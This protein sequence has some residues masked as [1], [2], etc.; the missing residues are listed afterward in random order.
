MTL[1]LFVWIAACGDDTLPAGRDAGRTDPARDSG[2][3]HGEDAGE[4]PGSDSGVVRF[5]AG[6]PS[7][8]LL[9]FDDYEYV[10]DR[11]D[12]AGRELFAA[13]GYP[14]SKSETWDE[15]ASGYIYTTTT[16][17]G[18]SEPFPG[19][20]SSRVLALEARNGTFGGQ[21][22]FYLEIG[23]A[24][25]STEQIP[26]NVWLQFWVLL[27]HAGE[28]QSLIYSNE[29]FLYPCRA[30]YPCHDLR[31]LVTFGVNSYQPF[32]ESLGMSSG[33]GA[34]IA[35]IADTTN[36]EIINPPAPEWDRWKLGHTD[37]S[38]RIVSNRWTLVRIHFDT[39]TTSG[40][41]EAWM[42]GYGGAWVQIARWIDGEGG[43]EWNIAP[44]AVGGHRTLRMPTT[45]GNFVEGRPNHDLWM[46]LDDF[47]MAGTMDALPV[48]PDEP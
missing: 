48:Y 34:F 10:V 12:A 25:G 5:D 30:E 39:S 6:A 32:N 28:E 2:G 47:A 44:D 14:W 13:Q 23:D 36:A 16:I 17:D 18:H 37:T 24:T 11:D 1:A 15:G 8:D 33:D 20:G 4:T 3:A 43:F 29:K 46:Y 35:N 22:D 21:T 41:Y 38:E 19:F 40:R 27:N 26:G 31:W 45:I 42:R 7:P 9:F